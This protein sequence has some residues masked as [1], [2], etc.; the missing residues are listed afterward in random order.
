MEEVF[1]DLTS[2]EYLHLKADN[3]IVHGSATVK[4]LKST[5]IIGVCN[6]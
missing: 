6:L 4:Y 2:F 3:Q 5:D 1:V